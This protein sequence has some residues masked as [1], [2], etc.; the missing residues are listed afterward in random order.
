MRCLVLTPFVP[1]PPVDGGRV[2]ILGLLDALAARCDVDLLSLAREE[3][4]HEAV[5]ALRRR[6]H[7]V[8][9]VFEDRPSAVSIGRAIAHGSSLYLAK[10]SSTAF[11]AT[12]ASRLESSL[13]DI[14]QCEY[15][16]TGQLITSAPRTEAAWVLD[17]HNVEHALSRQLERVA[18]PRNRPLYRLYARRETA[19]RL[20][21]EVAIC[22]SMDAVVTVSRP[23]AS[24]LANV[25]PGLDPVVVPNGVDLERLIPNED[26]KASRPSGLF[27][28]KLDY[29][30]NVDGLRWFVG[31]ILPLIL[32]KIP[33]FELVV[34]GSGDSRR[35][36]SALRSPGVRFVGR[37]DDVLPYF[38]ETWIVLA[39]LR[40]GSGT[41]LKILEALA[42]GSAV[43]TTPI[44][45]E[46]LETIADE[47]LLV[48]RDANDFA[49]S[50][51]RLCRDE[52]LR[53]RLGGAG[54]ALVERSYGWDRAGEL[55][56]NLYDEL[57]ERKAA[58]SC[59]TA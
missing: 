3:G 20:R 12:L 57:V 24:A 33:E 59:L 2:R 48:A 40:A 36:A 10:Y 22:S 8:Q 18:E 31:S 6:G 11:A 27:V 14:V 55:L 42:A 7:T 43:V 26:S 58:R 56:S 13:Y 15:P 23:D 38:Q 46:G 9:P 1:Y 35:V 34:A 32:G 16:Y 50:V 52:G 39:P 4:D 44:G 30:P 47:H 28:G 41:R 53:L 29:R 45:Q 25:V 51:V 17:A 49:K 21:E 37:V 5:G 19:A 54:R